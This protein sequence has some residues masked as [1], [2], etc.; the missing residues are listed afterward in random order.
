M[1]YRLANRVRV[2]VVVLALAACTAE[3]DIADE[4]TLERGAELLL[5]FKRDLQEALKSGLEKGPVEAISV[6]RFQAPAI[7]TS[8]SRDGIRLGRT[9]HRLRNP[10]N[11]SPGWVSPV[12]ESYLENPG[13]RAARIVPLPGGRSG[14]VEPIVLQPLCLSCHGETLAPDLAERVAELYPDDRA[15]GFNVGDLRGVFWVEFAMR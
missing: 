15:T 13:S 12:L 2:L 5:P 11:Q 14:Y 9:S 7:A 10:A 8:L 1:L 6:C 3:T 4:A